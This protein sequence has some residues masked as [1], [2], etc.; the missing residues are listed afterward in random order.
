MAEGC[1]FMLFQN[2][3]LDSSGGLLIAGGLAAAG[4]GSGSETVGI[5][6]LAEGVESSGVMRAGPS[7]SSLLSSSLMDSSCALSWR[8]L[9]L[10]ASISARWAARRASFSEESFLAAARRCFS[11]ALFSLP[12]LTSSSSARREASCSSRCFCSSRSCLASSSLYNGQY[13]QRVMRCS[14]MNVLHVLGLVSHRCLLLPDCLFL[15][16]LLGLLRLSIGL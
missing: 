8:S 7:S 13:Y 4:S 2:G 11:S 5:N 15:D 3:F 10:A 12:A 9:S 16:L 14:M 6:M 1:W